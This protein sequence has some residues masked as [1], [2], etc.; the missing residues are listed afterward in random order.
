MYAI[1]NISEEQ[2]QVLRKA[3]DLYMRIGL[4]QIERM[5]DVLYEAGF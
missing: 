3:L 1:K 4:G 5:S 2:L